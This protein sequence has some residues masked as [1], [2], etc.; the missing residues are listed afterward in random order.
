MDSSAPAAGAVPANATR[1]SAPPHA[2]SP[3]DVFAEGGGADDGDAAAPPMRGD[4]GRELAAA[5]TRDKGGA[6]P[7][8]AGASPPEPAA[9]PAAPA[10]PAAKPTLPKL[11]DK[12][13]KAADWEALKAN[14]AQELATLKAERDT[15]QRDLAAAKAAGDTDE[16]KRL[17]EE[18]KQYREIL[19]DVAI[20]RDPEFKARFNVR[21]KAAIDAAAQAAGDA[22]EKLTKLLALPS[23]PWR[24]EQINK[25]TEDL[26]ASSK[27][28]VEAALTLLEQVDVERGAEIASRRATFDEKQSSLLATQQQQQAAQRTQLDGVFGKVQSEWTEKHPFFA[29]REGDAAHNDAVAQTLTLARE[30]FNGQMSPEDLAAASFWAAS[31]ARVLDGWMKEK[32]AREA[33]EKQLDRLRGVQPSEG[34][35]DAATAREGDAPAQTA[36]STDLRS[37]NRGLREAQGRDAQTRAGARR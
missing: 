5:Q 19:R 17:R 21:E 4:F 13:T 34:R 31:G 25:L 15:Y 6:A 32:S 1:L 8:Q 29:P 2:Q 30:I 7:T 27:R 35:S 20:E 18:H 24:D 10:L 36:Y 9:T 33:A 3:A 12:P 23:T 28:R 26:S 14:H 22:G 37:F 11:P 16:V